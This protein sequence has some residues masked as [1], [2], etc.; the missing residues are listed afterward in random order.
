MK[1]LVLT[2]ALLVAGACA[3]KQVVLPPGTYAGSNA[4]DREVVIEIGDRIEVNG[5]R[6]R[7]R[8]GVIIA[9]RLAGKPRI[10]CVP[11]AK[12]EELR[13]EWRVGDDVETI[14]LVRL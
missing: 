13:C 9:D 12:G 4:A 3:P 8:E 6:A 5:K 7:R 10:T 14:E 11:Q 2:G 1:A